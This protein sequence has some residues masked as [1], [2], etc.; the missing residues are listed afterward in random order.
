M[1]VGAASFFRK[2][3]T[4]NALETTVLPAPIAGMDGRLNLAQNPMENC[5]FTYNLMPAEQGMK[6]RFGYREWVTDMVSTTGEGVR[7]IIPYRADAHQLGATPNDKLFAAT[8]EGIWDVT[9]STQTPSLVYPFV[10]VNEASGHGN[11]VQFVNDAGLVFLYYADEANGL[12]EYEA[13]VGIWNPAIGITGV[14]AADIVFVMVHKLRI[15]L[16]ERDSTNAW[17]LDVGAITGPA[18]KFTFGGKFQHGGDLVGL[19]NWTLDSGQGVDDILVAVGRGGDVIPYQGSDP[20]QTVSWSTIGT[21][22]IGPIPLGRNMASEYG[23]DLRIVADQGLPSMTDLLSGIAS[24]ESAQVLNLKIARF[25]RAV[26]ND[27]ALKWGFELKYNPNEGAVIVN[28]PQRTNGVYIQYVVNFSAQGWGLWRGVPGQAFEIWRGRMVFGTADNK[29]MRMDV[30]LDGIPFTGIGGDKVD[31][32]M[33]QAFS[34]AGAPT[35]YKFGEF[36]RADFL[37]NNP[38]EIN[39]CFNYDYDISSMCGTPRAVLEDEF[40]V[41]ADAG[42]PRV[43]DGIW[44]Q[45]IWAGSEAGSQYQLQGSWGVGRTIALAMRGRASDRAELVSTDVMWR[46]AGPF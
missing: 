39:T 9:G 40:S 8:N 29:L 37:S 15:W 18:T 35:R 11:S 21:F 2:P 12:L 31:F 10:I 41:W 28:T 17:Y 1:S 44:D 30:T 5:V 14:D 34:N 7:S 4:P 33:L 36:A 38:V 27:Y 13:G 42:A 19:Y 25:L 23:G 43:D 32:S 24:S 16:V 20:S 22:Y 26:V 45:S 46:A 3:D 6:T